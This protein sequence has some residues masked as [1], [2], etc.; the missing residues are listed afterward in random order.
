MF[1]IRL[2]VINSLLVVCFYNG[3]K[4]IK[5][6]NF[7]QNSVEKQCVM[8]INQHLR[9]IEKF[10]MNIRGKLH[11]FIEVSFPAGRST[12]HLVDQL[13]AGYIGFNR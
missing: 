1:S 8:A 12:K 9:N 5:S 3:F 2:C 7:L 4:Q 11:I 6:V 13:S 10:T